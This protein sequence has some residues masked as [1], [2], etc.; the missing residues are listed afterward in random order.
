MD[1]LEIRRKAKERAAARAAAAA[2]AEPRPDAG[3]APSGATGASPPEAHG[4]PLALDPLPLP[5]PEEPAPLAAPRPLFPEEAPLASPAERQAVAAALAEEAARIEAALAVRLDALPA[6]PDARFRTWRPQG[7]APEPFPAAVEPE[8][9]AP[10]PS[11][12]EPA[13][14]PAPPADPLEEFFYRVDEAGPRLGALGA[15]AAPTAAAAPVERVEYL[16]FLLGAEA[17]AVEI[18]QVR[19]VMRAPP[20]TEVPRAPADVLGVITVRGEVVAVFD[21]RR[22]LGLVGAPSAASGRVVIVDDGGGPCG[23][24]VD[25]V[26]SVVRLPRGA[27]EPCPNGIGGACAD[28]LAGIGRDRDRIFTVLEVPAVLRTARGS[29]GRAG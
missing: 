4:R 22:R 16:T 24:L 26:Q 21:P 17:Y 14:R 13:A 3:P 28:C 2:V 27:I 5:P 15:A 10:T 8:D 20:I 1:F 23:L 9:P 25:A 6:A 19:E 12:P 29:E 7:L 18:G 11:R